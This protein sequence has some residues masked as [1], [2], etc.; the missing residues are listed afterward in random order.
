MS[1][2]LLCIFLTLLAWEDVAPSTCR[3]IYCAAICHAQVVRGHPGPREFFSILRLRL[4][5]NGVRGPSRPSPQSGATPHI[6]PAIL[7]RIR[8]PAT[9]TVSY[10]DT[11]RWAAVVSFTLEKS[12]SP[13]HQL[14]CKSVIQ[15]L[16]HLST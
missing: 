5:Q 10:Q 15:A 16:T 4:V 2:A 6:S 7:R 9:P 13:P 14:Q 1:E 8:P 12:P 3:R 11:T